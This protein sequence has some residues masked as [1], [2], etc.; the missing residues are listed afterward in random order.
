[1]QMAAV[2]VGS[3]AAEQVLSRAEAEDK[4]LHPGERRDLFKI[5]PIQLE[6]LSNIILISMKS[7]VHLPLVGT[8]RFFSDTDLIYQFQCNVMEGTRDWKSQA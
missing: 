3:E 6:D 7:T 8:Q 5:I 4:F 2:M 1:M